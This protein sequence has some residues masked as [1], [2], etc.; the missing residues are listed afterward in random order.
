MWRNKH[1]G[2][3]SFAISAPAGFTHSKR[4]IACGKLQMLGAERLR[5]TPICNGRRLF[6]RGYF[7]HGTG[8][9]AAA[10]RADCARSRW[11]HVRRQVAACIDMLALAP[12]FGGADS[13]AHRVREICRDSK[14]GV[15]QEMRPTSGWKW[16]HKAQ[17]RTNISAT[18]A[19]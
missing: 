8:S 10:R 19:E 13:C 11:N 16:H 4:C 7:Q 6:C 15:R 18:G 2:D 17:L 12:Y 14:K 3:I 1:C 9:S 5:M